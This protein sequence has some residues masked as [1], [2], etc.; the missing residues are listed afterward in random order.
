MLIVKGV[1]AF[2]A[3]TKAQQAQVKQTATAFVRNKTQQILKDLVLIAPQWSGTSASSWGVVLHGQS[4]GAYNAR[5]L[6]AN[7]FWVTPRFRGDK[8][9]FAEAL[10]QNS[11]NLSSIRWNSRIS[12]V[13]QDTVAEALQS[14]EIPAENLRDGNYIDPLDVMGVTMVINKFRYLAG[15]NSEV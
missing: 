2:V 4:P 5:D 6:N 9:A 10:R 12:L 11:L 15:S 14:G 7:Q 1:N 13:N 3:K 8:E